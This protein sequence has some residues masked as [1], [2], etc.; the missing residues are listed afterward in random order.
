MVH[1]LLRPGSAQTT[2]WWKVSI[3][4]G[5]IALGIRLVIATNAEAPP[6]VV[7]TLRAVPLETSYQIPASGTYEV[8]LELPRD[9]PSDAL[10]APFTGSIKWQLWENNRLVSNGSVHGKKLGAAEYVSRDS[11]GWPVVS[12][13]A[14]SKAI[15]KL[16]LEPIELG[17]GGG[18]S[19]TVVVGRDVYELDNTIPKRVLQALLGIVLILVG[20]G[21]LVRRRSGAD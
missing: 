15:W 17:V 6:R 11:A 8:S 2:N 18:R 3:G 16:R 20:L 12:R 9:V 21:C 1:F 7:G 13:W 14:S 19:L 4:I 10:A 5:A